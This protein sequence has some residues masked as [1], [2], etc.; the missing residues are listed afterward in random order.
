MT[1]VAAQLAA[2]MAAAMAHQETGD[3]A[4]TPQLLAAAL[5]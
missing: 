4:V 2:M 5:Q 1:F 3:R